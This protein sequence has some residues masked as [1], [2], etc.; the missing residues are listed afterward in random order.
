ME[1]KPMLFSGKPFQGRVAVVTGGGTGLGRAMALRLAD[2]GASLVIASR[3]RDNL[4]PTAREIEARGVEC[5]VHE[6]DVRDYAKVEAMLPKVLERF[7]K[8][9]I[10]I[11]NAAGNFLCPAEKL[12]INGWNAVVG[13]V[14]H[15]TWHCTSVFGRQMIKQGRGNILSILA[16]YAWTGSPLVMPS[17]A[18]KAGV[19]AMTRSLAVEWGPKGIRI[20][21][22]A[23][24]A[25]VTEGASKN[26]AFATAEAQKQISKA[27]P[28]GRLGT[29]DELAD[30]AAFLLSDYS[31]YING[32]CVTMDGGSW[33]GRSFQRST[34]EAEKT[35]A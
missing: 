4:E 7:E 28:L 15:G 20:N 6:L 11:N 16:T 25:I 30:L 18:A 14:L 3:K 26:L 12:T 8:V 5:M 10:L 22:I 1:E 19:L 33:L 23:P 32:D 21:A 35:S 2:L 27:N 17:A 13:I 31:G 29:A 9:D 24:G 34:E